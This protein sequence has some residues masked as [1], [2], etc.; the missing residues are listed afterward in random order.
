MLPTALQSGREIR[1]LARGSRRFE[2]G[3][4]ES[5]SRQQRSSGIPSCYYSRMKA[6]GRN[7]AS[8]FR[9]ARSKSTRLSEGRGHGHDE[10]PARAL[11]RARTLCIGAWLPPRRGSRAN[12][13]G[14]AARR[15]PPPVR[16]LAP[17]VACRADG[18]R[19]GTERSSVLKRQLKRAAGEKERTSR[20]A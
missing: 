6:P 2:C 20:V 10:T 19:E 13:V 5:R 8:L 4:E 1:R 16:R 17:A 9:P 7:D 15:C 18:D 3:G 11:R 12:A 14:R